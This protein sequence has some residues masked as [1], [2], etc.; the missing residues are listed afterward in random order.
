MEDRIVE[1]G[2]GYKVY[3]RPFIS[4]PKFLE[5]QK[6]FASKVMIDPKDTEKQTIE[7]FSAAVTFEMEEKLMRYLIKKIED[8]EGKLVDI[9]EDYLPLPPDDCV[10]VKA[11][12]SEISEKA[13]QA[14]SK[15]K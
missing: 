11:V 8:K 7:P 13:A 6:D 14:Y 9:S 3:L 1:T 15:K 12:I 5:I 2:S 4:Y 10:E